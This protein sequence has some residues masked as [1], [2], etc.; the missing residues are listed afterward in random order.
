MNEITTLAGGCFWCTE[1][2]F[3]RING[4]I[5][6]IPGYAGGFKDNPSY[7]QVSNEET[8]HA[9]CIQITFDKDL[10]S[11]E[12]ILEIF[13]TIHN[14][15]TLNAQDND[16]GTQYRSIIFYHSEIQKNTA[17]KYIE[18]LE[19]Q[20]KFEKPVVTQVA[21]YTTFYPA[22]NYHKNYYE[23]NSNEPYCQFVILPKIAKL[24]DNFGNF[25]KK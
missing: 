16:V 17:K 3:K 2:L 9:E 14:P 8:G 21:E 15:T 23:N 10:V 4:V 6:V 24:K 22:E 20:K 18:K 5:T 11:Y 19:S 1:A 12:T 7:D 13:F 25:L